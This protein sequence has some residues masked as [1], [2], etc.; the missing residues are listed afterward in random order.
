[1]ARVL[2]DKGL[3][4]KFRILVELVNG[5]PSIQQKDVASRLGVTPQAISQYIEKL[6][7]DGW[8]VSD[9]RSKYRVTRVGVNWILKILRELGGYSALAQRAVTNQIL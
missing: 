5:Q 3:L 2:Q 6:I 8:V 9:G 1:M 4:T 7:D